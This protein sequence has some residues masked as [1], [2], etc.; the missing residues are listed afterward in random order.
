[1]STST[2][3]TTADRQRLRAARG[4][5]GKKDAGTANRLPS[6]PRQRRPALA[7]IALLLIV[8]GALVAGLL[9]IRMD[10]RVPVLAARHAIAPGERL[11]ENDFAEVQVA[12]DEMKYLLEADVKQAILDRGVFSNA[13]LEPGQILDRRQLTYKD[14]I[15][16]DRA[17]VSIVLSPALS[18]GN[19]LESGDLVEIVRAAG[20][21]AAGTQPERLTRGLVVSVTEPNKEDLGAGSASSANILVPSSVAADV[22]DASSANLAGLALISRGN[23][24]DDVTL[25]GF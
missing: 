6:P 19:E 12:A 15:G 7:A 20:T 23:S 24:I 8:G 3:Q 18:P 5:A 25:S 11:T 10:E 9:A 21:A 1:M 13:Y 14:P 16:T 17:L 22:I 4:T 2:G